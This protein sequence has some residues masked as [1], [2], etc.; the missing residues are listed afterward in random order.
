[1]FKKISSILIFALLFSSCALPDPNQPQILVIFPFFSS[2]TTSTSSLSINY[3]GSPYVYTI[4]TAISTATPVVSGTITSC[5]VSPS[6]P[7]GLSLSSTD[8]SISG[9][10]TAVQTSTEY[11]VTASGSSTSTSVSIFISVNDISPSS[12]TY[13]G[14]PYTMTSGA[15]I[16]TITPTY[17]GSLTDCTSNPALPTG[18]SL[19]TSDCSITGT[20]TTNQSATDYT[21]TASNSY[22]STTTTINITINSSPPSNLSYSGAPYTYTKDVAITSVSPTITGTATSYSVSP[23]LPTGL[24]INTTTG[25]LSGTPTAITST[26]TYTVTASNSAGSTTYGLD[27]TVNDAAPSSLSYSGTPY[28]YSKDVAITSVTPTVTGTPTSYS[29]SPTLPTGLAINTTSGVLSG[30]PTVNSSATTYTVTASNTGGSTTTTISI[31]VTSNPPSGLS[32]SG[33]PYVFTQNAAISTVTPSVT[34]TVTSC[35]SSPA[36]PSGLSINST[37][38]AIS[39][40]PTVISSKTH[41]ITATNMYGSTTASIDVTV[42]YFYSASTFIFKQNQVIS[43]LTPGSS[44]SITACSVSPSLPI[45]LSLSSACVLSGTPSSA[46]S[47]TSYTITPTMTGGPGSVTISIAVAATIYRVFVTSG[48]FT[49]NLKSNGSGSTGPAGADNLCGSDANKPSDGSTYKALLSDSSNRRACTSSDCSN[50]SQNIDWVMKANSTYV[51]SSDYASLFTTNAAGIYVYGTATN[52]FDSGV[53]KEYWTGMSLSGFNGNWVN[54]ANTGDCTG[55]TSTSNSGKV[56]SS[57][58]TD[59]TAIRNSSTISCSTAKYLLCVEQ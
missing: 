51:R 19:S 16:T 54:Y 8:C 38:C 28:S 24:S 15:A 48:T 52:P 2:T 22:G 1:M 47:A 42:N 41:A 27:I 39:G 23:S 26:A 3:S 25:V 30:T 5:S 9:T 36:L 35:S 56:G 37:T 10:P 58:Q 40:T 14:S 45:G 53:A 57:D 59:Y 12:L 44:S 33:S 49:A 18:L 31:T 13:S 17:N 50:P 6:L 20:P 29:V 43:T 32:Y 4:N 21:V 7:A 34:G 46:S 55:W 11:V